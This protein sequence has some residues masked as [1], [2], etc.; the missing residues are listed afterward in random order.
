MSNANN[1]F[2]IQDGVLK[3]YLG[4]GTS[5]IIP[6][7]VTKIGIGAFCSCT[8]L[9]S[10]SIP[11]GVT[12][13]GGEAFSCCTSLASVTIS[14]G[15][16]EIKISLGA[17]AC[18]T[19]LASVTI[20]ASVTEIGPEA[21][22]GCTSLSSVVISEGV[23]AIGFKAFEGCTSLASVIIPGSVTR[24]S[25]GA[26][27]ACNISELSHPCLT[28]RDGLVI[29]DGTLVDC[30][31]QQTENVV[32]PESVTEIGGGAFHGCTS[33]ASVVIPEG[34][35]KIGESAFEGCTSLASITIPESVKKIG[36][37]AF[38][39]CTSLASITIP[40]GVKKIGS[41]AFSGCPLLESVAIP[42]SV[43]EIGSGA[44]RDCTSLSSVS[45]PRNIYTEIAIS[46]FEGCN[47]NELS[48]P[49]LTIRNGLAIQDGILW[50]CANQ[51]TSVTIPRGVTKIG[52]G[53]F[54][55]CTSLESVTIP[56][57]VREIES[58]ALG[59]PSLKEINYTGTVAQYNDIFIRGELGA[60]EKDE[61]CSASFVT[62]A[63]GR[64]ELERPDSSELIR[65]REE[66][67]KLLAAISSDSSDS[68]ASDLSQ[69]T[70]EELVQAIAERSNDDFDID[71]DVLFEYDGSDSS[72]R[73]PKCVTEIGTNAFKDCMS[74]TS[75][76]IHS[77]V[78]VIGEAAF[79]GC[80]ALTEIIYEGTR[81]Q[82]A[83]VLK[84]RDWNKDVPAKN[85]IIMREY[86]DKM[87]DTLSPGEAMVLRL[88]YGLDGGAC[89]S[90]REIADVLG[91][92]K[93]RVRHIEN[94]ALQKIKKL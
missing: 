45:I 27:H 47:I 54:C 25:G 40:E 63:D 83:S 74:L 50:Y 37:L 52:I 72:V 9:T 41:L 1:D 17:F 81:E 10:V 34:V 33:L 13:I 66:V 12:E 7:G 11:E 89:R 65:R 15:V 93:E 90:L 88:R 48:H 31:R 19:S 79:S 77:G 36:S 28:V 51:K 60:D 24:I 42:K 55:R 64:V 16:K 73:I 75:V 53:A 3:K 62:C 21:F 85:V 20:P 61:W 44:F 86:I 32:I 91:V 78:T 38:S 92:S 49:S 59:C 84:C 4:S 76:T 68:H 46:A 43:K 2:D 5:V 35:K 22:S 26:F 80:T 30:T 69:D 58:F 29:R 71:D 23:K 14:E 82:W 18:C 56:A 39:G 67:D 70:I 87:I 8:S 6:E 94:T 57:S